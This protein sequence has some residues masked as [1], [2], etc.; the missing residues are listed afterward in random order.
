MHG[1]M[2]MPSGMAHLNFPLRFRKVLGHDRVDIRSVKLLENGTSIF[3]EMPDL[4]PIMQLHIRMHL[5]DADGTEF[6]TD[7]FCSPMFPDKPYSLKRTG[8]TEKR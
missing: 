8:R 2:N 3:V 5:Q 1:I 7:L 4:E 6:K